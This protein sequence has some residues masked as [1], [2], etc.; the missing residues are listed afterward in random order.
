MKYNL[1]SVYNQTIKTEKSCPEYWIDE[2]NFKGFNEDD[3]KW[4]K[5]SGEI[6]KPCEKISDSQLKSLKTAIKKR[7]VNW[8]LNLY[9][10]DMEK[11]R[12]LNCL[13]HGVDKTVRLIFDSFESEAKQDEVIK[14]LLKNGIFPE[15][16]I[17]DAI[18]ISNLRIYSECLTTFMFEPSDYDPVYCGKYARK[19]MDDGHY[20]AAIVIPSS[21]IDF[22]KYKYIPQYNKYIRKLEREQ[23]VKSEV[24][25]KEVEKYE[26]EVIK[27]NNDYVKKVTRKAI[28]EKNRIEAKIKR[29]ETELE[30]LYGKMANIQSEDFDTGVKMAEDI[31]KKIKVLNPHKAS[32]RFY[33]ILTRTVN[34][35]TKLYKRLFENM[36]SQFTFLLKIIN[37]K[38]LN[39]DAWIR[40]VYNGIQVNKADMEYVDYFMK[41]LLVLHYPLRVQLE[42]FRRIYNNKMHKI[43]IKNFKEVD[44]YF[45]ENYK[46]YEDL[47][48]KATIYSLKL[49][50]IL[51]ITLQN[52]TLNDPDG[53][54]NASKLVKVHEELERLSRDEKIPKTL[55]KHVKLFHNNK[56]FKKELKKYID[57]SNKQVIN[58]MAYLNTMFAIITSLRQTM[59]KVNDL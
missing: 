19:W 10:D 47:L 26:N 24:L 44:K 43:V 21:V 12:I 7:K 35:V 45:F 52:I 41:V 20:Y 34:D 30:L 32:S 48:I 18:T 5:Y 29:E 55:P 51:E 15:D 23:D 17:E 40:E 6:V 9:K 4:T 58:D 53:S 38:I 11:K 50:N 3:S 27:H 56:K 36:F 39:R 54:P 31:L 1:C 16:I 25:E 59:K 22:V 49:M 14:Y 13:Y 42:T 37:N 57:T 8:F 33:D 28:S 46:K 2:R